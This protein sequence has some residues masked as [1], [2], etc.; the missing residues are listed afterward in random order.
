MTEAG[1]ETGCW[2]MQ[3]SQTLQFGVNGLDELKYK[4]KISVKEVWVVLDGV[5]T[6][7]LII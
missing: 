4:D 2:E 5:S 6:S 7:H 1:N 3:L